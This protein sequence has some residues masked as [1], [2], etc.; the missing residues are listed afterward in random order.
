[1]KNSYVDHSNENEDEIL[2]RVLAQSE[3]EYHERIN[4]NNE[5]KNERCLIN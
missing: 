4:K 3:K 2:A 5:N 1:L